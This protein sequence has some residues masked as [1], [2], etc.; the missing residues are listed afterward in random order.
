MTT[1]HRCVRVRVYDVYDV[2]FRFGRRRFGRR[3]GR[4]PSV[5]VVDRA[6]LGVI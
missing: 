1:T 2:E 5:V 3:F 4:R 6:R